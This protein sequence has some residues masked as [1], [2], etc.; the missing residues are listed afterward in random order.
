MG[1]FRIIGFRRNFSIFPMYIFLFITLN[2]VKPLKYAFVLMSEIKIP[3]LYTQQIPL[4]INVVQ[5]SS[6][7]KYRMW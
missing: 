2:I 7:I 3:L 4:R 1:N 5:S 6:L